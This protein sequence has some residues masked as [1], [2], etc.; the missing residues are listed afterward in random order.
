MYGDWPFRLTSTYEYSVADT[1][2]R[3]TA[4]TAKDQGC[5]EER[6]KYQNTVYRRERGLADKYCKEDANF[7]FAIFTRPGLQAS[8]SQGIDVS[9]C[10]LVCLSHPI[11]F[12]MMDVLLGQYTLDPQFFLQ[13]LDTL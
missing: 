9:V 12:F 4:F 3:H 13:I 5:Q 6:G 2:G 7:T 10:L 1:T 11:Y 8:P